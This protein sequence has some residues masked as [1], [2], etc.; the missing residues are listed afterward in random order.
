MPSRPLKGCGLCA[1]AAA[2]LCL[3]VVFV[4]PGSAASVWNTEGSTLIS[5]ATVTVNVSNIT[6][7]AN[8]FYLGCHSDSGF[9]HQP[10]GFY[11]QMIYGESFEE[12]VQSA[13]T[14]QVK[15]KGLLGIHIQKPSDLV[16]VKDPT[17]RIRHCDYQAFATENE[18]GDDDFNFVIIPALNG[19]G[20]SAVSL[21]SVNFPTMYL[22]SAISASG[23]SE[24]GRLGLAVATSDLDA[25]SF[26]MSNVSGTNSTS[27]VLQSL[28]SAFKGYYIG[29]NGQ[30][31]GGCAAHYDKVSFLPHLHFLR[32]LSSILDVQPANNTHMLLP[33]LA[34]NAH[35][36]LS[37]WTCRHVQM[38][39]CSPP[40]RG[41]C[42]Q[43]HQ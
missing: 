14:P 31:T 38:L 18:S 8:Q 10:R 25:A 40:A 12:S 15:S 11:S 3:V 32:F 26:Q 34:A 22:T 1:A 5:S 43:H 4:V 7:D 39:S 23:G 20:S 41:Q 2:A 33:T 35:G 30:L 21:Q 16:S 13:R 36:R 42:P 28:S 6:H 9:T 24:P 29:M 27:I 19:A 37:T 17:K